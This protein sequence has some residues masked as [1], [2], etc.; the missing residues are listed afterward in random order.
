MQNAF[1]E[2]TSAKSYREQQ[3][4]EAKGARFTALPF[5]RAEADRIV[6]QAETERT[7]ILSRAQ[8]W[9]KAFH[10]LSESMQQNRA[11]GMQRMWL[12]SI[13]DILGRARVTVL[14]RVP[15]GKSERFYLPTK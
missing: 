9:A 2:V 10:A 8:G 1:N 13:E 12:Q 7:E 3:L 6:Q 11:L 5:A 14:P 4:S 15:A